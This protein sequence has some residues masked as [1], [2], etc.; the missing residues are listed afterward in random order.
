MSRCSLY[1][2]RFARCERRCSEQRSVENLTDIEKT[3]EGSKNF[4]RPIMAMTRPE[5][6][7]KEELKALREDI[8][9]NLVSLRVNYEKRLSN[10][11]TASRSEIEGIPGK[12]LQ[13]AGTTEFTTSES[14]AGYVSNIYKATEGAV[15]KPET[16]TIVGKTA[17]ALFKLRDSC[18]RPYPLEL[19]DIG[20]EYYYK[21]LRAF[22]L[23]PKQ[24]GE[25]T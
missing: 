7:E 11:Q 25:S 10:L 17:T 21:V 2:R 12:F 13:A 22:G 19:R 24:G 18:A 5:P 15:L 1:L 14:L 23:R 16:L 6:S 9:G 4:V 3:S 20:Y 8:V